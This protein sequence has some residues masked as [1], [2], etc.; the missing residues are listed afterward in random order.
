MSSEHL[1]TPSLL[2]PDFG[3][4]FFCFKFLDCVGLMGQR[5]DASL[6]SKAELILQLL[7]AI[8]L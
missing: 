8:F 1:A 5:K 2:T 7:K 4:T 6:G 3:M